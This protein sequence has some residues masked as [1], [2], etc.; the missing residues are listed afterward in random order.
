MKY[1]FFKHKRLVVI[2]FTLTISLLLSSCG[3]KKQ[4]TPIQ[5]EKGGEYVARI[6]IKDFGYVDL[7]L[8]EAASKTAVDEFK[9]LAEAGYYNGNTIKTV[10]DDYA[11]LITA[12][13]ENDN[14]T[15]SDTKFSS[16]INKDYYPFR[17]SLCLTESGNGISADQFMIITADTEFL[18]E[19]EKLLAYKKVTPAE[20]YKAAYGTELD[21]E[22]LALFDTYGGAPW[23][24]GHCIVF[25]QIYVG[26][27]VIDA[28]SGVDIEE[29]SSYTPVEELVIESIE[30][31]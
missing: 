27:D 23:L 3:E 24:Y 19:L 15:G 30:V 4:K 2:I 7:N 6:H 11:F 29:G 14:N 18:K 1:S 22:T 31:K 26:L 16:E 28:V 20:Y 5:M 25:G 17:G 21:D 12:N 9:R 8:Y 10:I 13:T